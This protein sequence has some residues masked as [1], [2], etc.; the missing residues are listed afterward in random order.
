M[1]VALVFGPDEG[2]VRERVTRL[3]KTVVDDLADPFRVADLTAQSV[4]ADP[5]SLA[6]EAQAMAL[7]GGRRVVRLRDAD[8]SLSK[9]VEAVLQGAATDTLV[10]LQG[11]DLSARSSLRKLVEAAANGAAVPCYLDDAMAVETVIR[12]SL[13]VN[14]IGVQS[15]Q[16]I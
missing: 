5:A 3:M 7:T 11:G 16:H 15:C 1:R 8:D 10:V 9:A 2:L 4:K 6:D 12:D 14:G 13:A